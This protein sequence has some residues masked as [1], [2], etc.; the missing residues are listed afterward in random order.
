MTGLLSR[1]V[2]CLVVATLAA[3]QTAPITGREQFILVSDS[4]ANQMGAQAYQ[5]ILSKGRVSRDPQMNATVARVSQRL[6]RVVDVPGA[7]WQYTVFDD[8]TPNAFALPGGKIGVNTGMFRVARTE[9]QLAAVISHEIG[10][11]MAR[12]SAE[13][14]SREVAVQ[15]GV[16]LLGA[17]TNTAQYA[18]VM[19]Q[20]ATLGLILPFNREQESEADEIGLIHMARAGYDP[21]ESIALW[22]NM[23]SAGGRAPIEFLSTHPS[24]GNRI[25]RLQQAMPRA[26]ADYNSSPLRSR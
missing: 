1:P 14:M 6:A 4:E 2:A 25:A 17:A 13:R 19:A 15:V 22:Q 9:G 10:H 16:G 7:Q 5:E 3:C 24:P 23:E 8:A 11:V 21:R 12:H 20:A 26:L 18:E